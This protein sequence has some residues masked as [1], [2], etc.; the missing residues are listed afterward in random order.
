[1]PNPLVYGF[2]ISGA[3]YRNFRNLYGIRKMLMSYHWSLDSMQNSVFTPKAYLVRDSDSELDSSTVTLSLTG[4]FDNLTPPFG[5]S[6]FHFRNFGGANSF[7]NLVLEIIRNYNRT[8]PQHVRIKD[9]DKLI[10]TPY[11][12]SGLPT[13]EPDNFLS[14][15]LEIN[16]NT[17]TAL[18]EQK[19]MMMMSTAMYITTG[20]DSLHPSPP[21]QPDQVE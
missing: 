18:S 9:I 10:F 15:K 2:E 7:H 17:S 20:G 1:M 6:T 21:A 11:V 12:E 5:L 14:L 4:P 3:D 13:E 16:F 19:V 8:H